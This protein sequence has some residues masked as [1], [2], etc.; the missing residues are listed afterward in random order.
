M[1]WSA[2]EPGPT[3]GPPPSQSQSQ[4]ERGGST[5][6]PPGRLADRISTVLLL[7][8]GAILVI[9]V[10]IVALIATISATATCDAATGCSPGGYIGGASL[11]VGGAF[12]IGVATVV[13]AIGAW[14]RRRTSWWIAAVGFLLA[15]ACITWGGVVFAG[16]ADGDTSSSSSSTI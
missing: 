1:T 2:P 13:L 5:L 11:A 14:I 3:S 12:V 4:W 10:A 8:F 9:V 7:A 6:F 15:V 16:A